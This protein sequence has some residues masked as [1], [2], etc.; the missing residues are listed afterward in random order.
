MTEEKLRNLITA[1]AQILTDLG[2]DGGILTTTKAQG[3]NPGGIWTGFGET[4]IA[5]YWMDPS[6]E[7]IPQEIKDW[8]EKEDLFLEWQN[9]G[10]VCIWPI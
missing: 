3:Y 6:F 5:D 9:P 7:T 10:V 1:L 8:L 4:Q 2:K